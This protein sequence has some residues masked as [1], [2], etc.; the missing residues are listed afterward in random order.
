MVLT[1]ANNGGGMSNPPMRSVVGRPGFWYRAE[2][3]MQ[4][5]LDAT[6]AEYF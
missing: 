4:D 2:D 1:L 6:V 5:I 3:S